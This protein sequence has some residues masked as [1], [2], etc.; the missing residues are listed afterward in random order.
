MNPLKLHTEVDIAPLAKLYG[1][2]ARFFAIGSCFAAEIGERLCQSGIEITV[3]PFGTLYNPASIAAA[4]QRLTDATPFTEEDVI[5]SEPLGRYNSFWHHTKFSNT[6]VEG[7]LTGANAALKSSSEAFAKAEVC[8]VTL[9]TAW[10]FRHLDSGRFVANCNKVP[11][12]E[13]RRER[14]SV[15]DSAR[16][17]SEMVSANPGKEWIFTVSPIRH[18]ADGA[19]GN[20]LSK[21]TLLLATGQLQQDFPNVHYF[22]AFEIMMDELRDYRFYAENMTHPSSQS[23]EIIF[24]RFLEYVFTPAAV[25]AAIKARK[26]W[27]RNMH[28]PLWETSSDNI[29]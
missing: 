26:E 5:Y 12:K 18:L 14:L 13:F 29:A 16:L 17:L 1:S 8:L 22:P 10:V 27:R 25:E 7:F 19:Y 11:A 15:E 23:A 4:V 28:R 2:D 6:S 3:N 20:S 24:A 9:G 21:A